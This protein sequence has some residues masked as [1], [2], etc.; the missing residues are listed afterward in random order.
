M[1]LKGDNFPEEH[2]VVLISLGPASMNYVLSSD[3]SLYNFLLIHFRYLLF[4]NVHRSYKE[5]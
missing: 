4:S 3:F 1:P 2:F 5:G